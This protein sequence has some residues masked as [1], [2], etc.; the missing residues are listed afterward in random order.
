M[1]DARKAASIFSIDKVWA[2]R[3]F[4]L[5]TEDPAQAAQSGEAL[6]ESGVNRLWDARHLTDGAHSRRRL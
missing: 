3:A 4:G 2:G 6:F 1:D 5:S